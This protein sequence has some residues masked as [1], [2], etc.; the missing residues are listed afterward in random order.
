MRLALST[1]V[2]FPLLAC[3]LLGMGFN[4]V[5]GGLVA[6]SGMAPSPAPAE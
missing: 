3:L 5:V 6:T 1:V 4:T 2:V